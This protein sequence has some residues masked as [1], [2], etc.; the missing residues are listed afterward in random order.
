M[1]KY[2]FLIIGSGIVGMTIA[3]AL[4]QKH[5]QSKILVLEKEARPGVH[6]SGRN[7][8]VVHA[9]IYYP[10]ST[11][12]AKLCVQGH[13]LMLEYLEQNRLP[14]K[15]CG[16][17][18][19][20]PSPEDL[21]SLQMLLDRARANGVE[22]E[23]LSLSQLRE[24][25]P[26]A[27]S[28][29]WAIGSPRTAIL[30]TPKLMQHL[31]AE[32]KEA[33]IEVQFNTKVLKIDDQKCEVQTPTETIGYS[34]LINSS[35]VHC[36]RFAH[37]CGVG[38]NYRILPFKGSYWKATP[39]VAARVRGLIY[40]VPDLNVPFLGVHVT[41]TM[42]G[43][44]TFGPSAMPTLGR[45][46]Y[47]GGNALNQES[48]QILWRLG[49]LWWHNPQHFRGYA[50]AEIKR[51]FRRPFFLEAQGLLE[52]LKPQEI[53]AFYK[54]GI[55]PQLLDLEKGALEMDFVVKSGRNSTHILNAISPAFTCS[56]AFAQ[57]VSQSL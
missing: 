42:S 15:I 12:K 26:S 17:V 28:Q 34:H 2:D 38:L 7:S 24:R 11:L 14:H 55:R 56:F 9:G 54:V 16:K 51:M 13:R 45:E 43:D 10:P 5:S 47:S 29:E 27:H 20:A 49:S 36:D 48:V 6:A 39:S 32:L 8:G 30:D 19:V 53:G 40:P 35:G 1:R 22:V 33:G 44:V 21:P 50:H 25:E 31:E 4:K 23:P 46:S 57:H 3:R 52:D 37:M 18:I 41:K